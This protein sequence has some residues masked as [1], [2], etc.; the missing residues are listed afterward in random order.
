MV[1]ILTISVFPQNKALQKTKQYH[2]VYFSARELI[3][4]LVLIVTTDFIFLSILLA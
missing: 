2:F 1:E 4:Q 3:L